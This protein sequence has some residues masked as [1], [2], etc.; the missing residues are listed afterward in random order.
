M[1]NCIQCGDIMPDVVDGDTTSRGAREL[2]EQCCC[3]ERCARC[4]ESYKRTAELCREA[5]LRGSEEFREP[6]S[7][8]ADNEN[9]LLA[10]LR[11][12]LEVAK[13]F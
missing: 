2:L 5:I 11:A 8:A 13:E 10:T 7:A 6:E 3:R 4:L 9:R 1:V 12:R